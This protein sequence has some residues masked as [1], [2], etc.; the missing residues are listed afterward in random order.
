M[1]QHSLTWSI[2]STQSGYFWWF[3]LHSHSPYFHSTHNFLTYCSF[4]LN[5]VFFFFFPFS[6]LTNSFTHQLICQFLREHTLLF[7]IRWNP[8]ITWSQNTAHLSGL[9]FL[10]GMYTYICLYDYSINTYHAIRLWLTQ[11]QRLCPFFSQH[12]IAAPSL[13][14]AQRR[15]SINICWINNK[16]KWMRT[17]AHN[18]RRLDADVF[19]CLKSRTSN[20]LWRGKYYI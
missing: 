6:S 16:V 3:L 18:D 19:N 5:C 20:C 8:P 13:Y 15:H 1:L 9:R 7:L 12:V 10:S 4:H 11:K 17:L 2:N 14:L